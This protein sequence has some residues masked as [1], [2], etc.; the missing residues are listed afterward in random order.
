MAA[1]LCVDHALAGVTDPREKSRLES[2]RRRFEPDRAV[3]ASFGPLRLVGTAT[4]PDHVARG[5]N[6]PLDL[7]WRCERP[8]ARLYAVFVHFHGPRGFQSD[9]T[10]AGG[11]IP[12]T[13]WIA[14]E[15]I[16]DSFTVAVPSDA[17]P[18]L[19]T[20]EVGLW[21]PSQRRRLRGGWFGKSSVDAFQI[22]VTE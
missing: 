19:Y 17:P 10:P 7:F 16:R 13:T 11:L 18:G 3:E 6:L 1:S 5:S 14:G 12:T 4:V 15:T 21:D 20:A 22:R 9:H 2:L 8:V